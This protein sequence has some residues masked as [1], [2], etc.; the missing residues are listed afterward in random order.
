MANKAKKA[1]MGHRKGHG[2]DSSTLVGT[3]AT[4]RT[5]KPSYGQLGG[6]ARGYSVFDKQGEEIAVGLGLWEAIRLAQESS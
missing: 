5:V 6:L 2:N 3:Y 4:G 1:K